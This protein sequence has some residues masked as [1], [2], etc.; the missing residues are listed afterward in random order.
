MT[1]TR[2]HK[3]K[4]TSGTPQTRA[5]LPHKHRR[6]NWKKN[7]PIPPKT[8]TVVNQGRPPN[9]SHALA[10]GNDVVEIDSSSDS[11]LSSYDTSTLLAKLQKTHNKPS[12]IKRTADGKDETPQKGKNKKKSK[13]VSIIDSSD[14]ESI[15]SIASSIR[16]TLEKT[17]AEDNPT[18]DETT[19]GTEPPQET[20]NEDDDD[21]DSDP[22]F[23]PEDEPEKITDHKLSP[24]TEPVSK[25]EIADLQNDIKNMALPTDPANSAGIVPVDEVKESDDMANPTGPTYASKTTE[26]I[27]ATTDNPPAATPSVPPLIKK[28]FLDVTDP[29]KSLRFKFQMEIEDKS[30]ALSTIAEGIQKLHSQ[31]VSEIGPVCIA[32]WDTKKYPILFQPTTL[33]TGTGQDT[34]KLTQILGSLPRVRG[35]NGSDEGTYWGQL[36]FACNNPQDLSIPLCEIGQLSDT[37]AELTG[38]KLNKNCHHMPC[39]YHKSLGYFQY[40]TRTMDSGELVKALYMTLN[41]PANVILRLQWRRIKDDTNKMY[42]YPEDRT[43]FPPSAL[44]IDVNPEAEYLVM[45]ILANK[46]KKRARC[47][48]LGLRLR[49]IPG[50]D[51]H[52]GQILKTAVIDTV[53]HEDDNEQRETPKHTMLTLHQKQKY[54]CNTHVKTLD[55]YFIVNLDHGVQNKYGKAYSLRQFIMARTPKDSVTDRLFVSVD[56]KYNGDC[57]VLTTTAPHFDA[58]QKAMSELVPQTLALFGHKAARWWTEDALK[59]HANCT[60]DESKGLSMGKEFDIADMANDDPFAM[61]EAFQSVATTTD[62]AVVK[63]EAPVNTTSVEQTV[64]DILDKRGKADDD[65]SLGKFIDRPHDGDTVMTEKPTEEPASDEKAP[66][67][68]FDNITVAVPANTDNQEHNDAAS[69]STMGTAHTNASTGTAATTTS[70]RQNLRL[71]K[72]TS[73]K[74]RDENTRLVEEAE[75]NQEEQANQRAH[76]EAENKRLAEASRL[77]HEQQA[78]MLAFLKEQGITLPTNNIASPAAAMDT[79]HTRFAPVTPRIEDNTSTPNPPQNAGVASGDAGKDG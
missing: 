55:C 32:A 26:N 61:N 72:K 30:K 43:S 48:P 71:E 11:S 27:D 10:R 75:L 51:S 52:K 37:L 24:F 18:L 2:S 22:L 34:T 66:M 17:F 70:T 44:H 79:N 40:S 58:A 33:P 73:S 5:K 25:D 28:K 19:N 31:L 56:R 53:L 59:M 20:A 45:D 14:E 65:Q 54:F 8:D 57:H 38:V 62:Y 76:L 16:K 35:K 39:P 69:V 13:S 29:D 50:F 12:I 1:N 68:S 46:F 74:L 78:R 64:Q 4:P 15:A 9:I 77:M 23:N 67:V 3:K 21:E 36:H 6:G 47:R 41:L 63:P 49:F 60:W 7:A 42:P